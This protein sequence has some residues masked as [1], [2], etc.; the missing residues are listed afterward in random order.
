[1]LEPHSAVPLSRF[2]NSE[3]AAEVGDRAGRQAIIIIEKKLRTQTREICWFA[4]GC[5][6]YSTIA[7]IAFKCALFCAITSFSTF[8]FG[9]GCL[10]SITTIFCCSILSISLQH[11]QMK[12]EEEG[13]FCAAAA[14]ASAGLC[15]CTNL[16][17]PLLTFFHFFALRIRG[18]KLMRFLSTN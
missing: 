6:V 17:A 12:C 5:Q 8:Y 2:A 18:S 10:F 3:N 14:A 7:S 11:H 15:L 4:V 1:M 16:Y 13:S 9:F